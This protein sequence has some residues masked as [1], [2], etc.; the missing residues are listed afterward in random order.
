MNDDEVTRMRL[1]NLED[2]RKEQIVL[3]KSILD[4]LHRIEL[5]MQNARDTACPM[6]GHCKVLE[7]NIKGKWEADKERFERLEARAEENDEWKRVMEG[8][9]DSLKSTVNKGLG[10]VGILVVAMP[11]LT[12]FAIN[13]L[14]NK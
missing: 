4:T 3:N 7:S 5:G 9:M 6:P 12:W 11:L 13:Y 8:K 14:V 1:G 10:G 2:F